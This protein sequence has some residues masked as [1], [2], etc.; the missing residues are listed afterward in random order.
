MTKPR[1]ILGPNGTELWH[2]EFDDASIAPHWVEV[3]TCG[4]SHGDWKEGYGWLGFSHSTGTSGNSTSGHFLV[5]DIS[6]FG[7][8]PL[9]VEYY[10][11]MMG[12]ETTSY[13]M[14]LSA[15]SNSNVAGSGTQHMQMGH[16]SVAQIGDIT[17]NRHWTGWNAQTSYTNFGWYTDMQSGY[18]LRQ[19]WEAANTFRIRVSS[20]GI[21]WLSSNSYALTLTPTYFGIGCTNYNTGV[22]FAASYYY[23]RVYG[24]AA[25]TAFGDKDTA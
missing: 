18:Y 9:T 24:S 3:D 25:S 8:P 20:D 2:D 10:V 4:A 6:A 11:R 23:V 14:Q 1:P 13:S 21:S 16:S 12:N 22:A 7:G 17:G 5:A 15:Y 19:V